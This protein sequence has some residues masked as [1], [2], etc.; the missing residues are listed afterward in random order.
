MA[1]LVLGT[2]LLTTAKVLTAL[3]LR[4]QLRPYRR[5]V[6]LERWCELRECRG[7]GFFYK[8]IGHAT[9]VRLRMPQKP[10]HRFGLPQSSRRGD[11]V[12]NA[13]LVHA[14]SSLSSADPLEHFCRHGYSAFWILHTRT[15]YVAVLH[16]W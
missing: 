7:L 1:S 10:V 13:A 6:A 12:E 8:A 14:I 3:L 9:Q 2:V 16:R 4:P 5:K 15:L 11:N